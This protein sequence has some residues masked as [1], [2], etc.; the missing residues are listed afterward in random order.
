M[1]KKYKL[2]FNTKNIHSFG[3]KFQTSA[4]KYNVQPFIFLMIKEVM[5]KIILINWIK[6]LICL[7]VG[8]NIFNF[9]LMK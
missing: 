7:F 4:N 8:S 6:T 5:S 1:K 3:L 9:Q 2:L